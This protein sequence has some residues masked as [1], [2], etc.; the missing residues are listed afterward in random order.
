MDDAGDFF[1]KCTTAALPYGFFSKV[2][3]I[4]S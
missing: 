3:L 4:L 1:F 2:P